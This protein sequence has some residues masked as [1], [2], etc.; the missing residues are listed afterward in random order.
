[1]LE[2]SREDIIDSIKGTGAEAVLSSLSAEDSDKVLD[3]LSDG[4]RLKSILATPRAR[5][6]LSALQGGK[7]WIHNG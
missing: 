6:L 1:M 5:A 2:K 7:G 4:E 3:I